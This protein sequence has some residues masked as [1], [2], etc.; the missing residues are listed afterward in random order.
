MATKVDNT[1]DLYED[2]V[3]KGLRYLP[4]WNLVS[5]I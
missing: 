3:D 2:F 4:F 1:I 5:V